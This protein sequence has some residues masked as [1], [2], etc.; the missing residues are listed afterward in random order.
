MI[1]NLGV[2]VVILLVIELALVYAVTTY[3]YSSVRQYLTSKVSAVNGLL[4]RYVAD[5]TN[6]NA[7]LR[8]TF[9]SFS[10]KDKM[11]L[12]AIDY[13]GQSGADLLRFL[14][15]LHRQYAGL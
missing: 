10:D 14:A 2:I 6:L 1:Q 3:F 13:E 15:E 5:G 11:E 4:T 8:S 12:M 7:E 9:E